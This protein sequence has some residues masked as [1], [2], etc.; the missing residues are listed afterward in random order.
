M[1][2]DL[3]QMPTSGIRVQACGDA[4]LLNFG[5]YAAPDRRL[6]FSITPSRISLSPTPTRTSRITSG[7]CKPSRP[8]ACG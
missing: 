6:V 1:A 7:Y 8:G 2:W 3:A 5:M 4:H